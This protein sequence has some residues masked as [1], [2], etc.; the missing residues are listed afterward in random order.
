M[1][2]AAHCS[3]CNLHY[4]IAALYWTG[5]FVVH[6]FSPPLPG[7]TRAEFMGLVWLAFAPGYFWLAGALLVCVGASFLLQR[8]NGVAP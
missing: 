4:A 5:N 6:L 7:C 8:I 1:V 2:A 3:F